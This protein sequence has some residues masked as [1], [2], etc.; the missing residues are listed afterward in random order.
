MTIMQKSQ[1]KTMYWIQTYI[2]V[3]VYKIYMYIQALFIDFHSFLFS[4]TCIWKII[5][6]VFSMQVYICINIHKNL[7]CTKSEHRNLKGI[8]L[9]IQQLKF[10]KVKYIS[11]QIEGIIKY[12]TQSLK[13]AHTK[14]HHREISEHWGQRNHPVNFQKKIKDHQKKC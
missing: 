2:C 3:C 12:L 13:Q 5:F 7:S 9:L 1:R 8:K 11:F 10:S 4:N 14:V 6:N